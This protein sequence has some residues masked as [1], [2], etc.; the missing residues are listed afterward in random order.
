MTKIVIEP[1]KREIMTPGS[2]GPVYD[3]ADT[4]RADVY[5]R[6]IEK[7]MPPGAKVRTTADKSRIEI[8]LPTE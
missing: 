3:K 5:M 8:L 1:T 7:Q 4:R 6:F 2:A